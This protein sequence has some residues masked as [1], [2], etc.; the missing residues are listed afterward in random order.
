MSREH[1]FEHVVSGGVA[2]VGT[3]GDKAALAMN[4]RATQ[5]CPPGG[6]TQKHASPGHGWPGLREVAGAGFEPATSR[7]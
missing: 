6:R 3:G 7:L 5:T 4:V 2:T 1:H